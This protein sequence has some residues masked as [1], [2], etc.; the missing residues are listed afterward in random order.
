MLRRLL[1]PGL[2]QTRGEEKVS[3]EDI[4]SQFPI[5]LLVW[6]YSIGENVSFVGDLFK[7]LLLTDTLNVKKK[8]NEA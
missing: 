5:I 2:Y 8:S 1:V 7:I 4:A 6:K 3:F